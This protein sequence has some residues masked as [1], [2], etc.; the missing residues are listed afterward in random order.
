M[1]NVK[2]LFGGVNMSWP[3]VIV[4]ALVAGLY[5]GVVASIPALDGTSLR[6]IAIT[7]EW[8]VIFAFVIASNCTSGLESAVKTFVFFLISQPLIYG[9]QVLA[10]TLDASMAW[11]YYSEIWGPATLFTFPGGFIA[12]RITR[13]DWLGVF[14][15]GLG[16]TIQALMCVS[17]GAQMLANPP[18][19][20]L[21]TIICLV[22]IFVMAFQIQH[23]DKR[24]AATLLVTLVAI[25]I[26]LV[27]M[28]TTGRSLY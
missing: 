19:H 14:I 28:V 11:Y 8:W 21:S 9:V 1:A 13:Q 2:K 22:S 26:I 15:L 7:Y 4:F 27:L 12:Q 23:T 16:N 6:D 10:G 20:L 18:F 3:V 5:A 17:H 25:A 24:R